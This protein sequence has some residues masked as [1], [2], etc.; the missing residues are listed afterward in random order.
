MMF[1]LEKLERW[2]PLERISSFKLKLIL[3]LSGADKSSKRKDILISK[4]NY[5]LNL[6]KIYLI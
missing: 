6:A 5:N 4:I 2:E 1:R 3:T